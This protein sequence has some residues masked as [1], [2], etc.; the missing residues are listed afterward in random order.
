MSQ[1]R[2]IKRSATPP[3]QLIPSPSFFPAPG[4]KPYYT[5]NDYPP[6]GTHVFFHCTTNM[7]SRTPSIDRE[8]PSP[9]VTLAE[10]R[11]VLAHADD[12]DDDTSD[13]SMT[14]DDTD[15]GSQSRP[16]NAER[17]VSRI[18][19]IMAESEANDTLRH[20][21]ATVRALRAKLELELKTTLKREFDDIVGRFGVRREVML[22]RKESM[23]NAYVVAMEAMSRAVEEL[24]TVGRVEDEDGE[25]DDGDDDDAPPISMPRQCKCH[26]VEPS[27]TSEGTDD[28]EV[29]M[30]TIRDRVQSFITECHNPDA[31]SSLVRCSPCTLPILP[32]R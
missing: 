16:A 24:R 9:E 28:T 11:A 5:S 19:S 23:R 15:D 29:E 21:D 26:V 12:D 1:R 31:A 22:S 3:S 2:N 13:T 18:R 20:N 14:S 17:L 4:P 32:P 8:I 10:I 30:R 6:L 27:T 25:S 7:L